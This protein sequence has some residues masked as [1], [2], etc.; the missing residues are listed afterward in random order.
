MKYSI[1]SDILYP[2]LFDTLKNEIFT[3]KKPDQFISLY[4]SSPQEQHTNSI[5]KECLIS[6]GAQPRE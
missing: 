3:N 1:G 4:W 5:F 2:R 6:P